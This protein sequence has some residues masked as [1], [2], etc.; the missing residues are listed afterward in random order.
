VSRPCILTVFN[1]NKVHLPLVDIELVNSV[2]ISAVLSR[3]RHLVQMRSDRQF[4][5]LVG[6]GKLHQGD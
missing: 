5:F 4:V 3:A 1:L 6:K 2:H